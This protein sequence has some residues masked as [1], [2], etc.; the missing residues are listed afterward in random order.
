V[1]RDVSEWVG[2]VVATGEV[3]EAAL[4]ARFEADAGD[5]AAEMVTTSGDQHGSTG[6]RRRLIREMTAAELAR[7]TARALTGG[8]R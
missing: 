5:F 6:Y 4:R 7:A 3:T 1:L 2:G 8:E